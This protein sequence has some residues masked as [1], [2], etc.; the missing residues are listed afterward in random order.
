M[1]L[2]INEN[3]FVKLVRL[4]LK[5]KRKIDQL[6]KQLQDLKRKHSVNQETLVEAKKGKE[7]SVHCFIYTSRLRRIFFMSGEAGFSVMGNQ[8]VFPIPA[9]IYLLKVNN[10]NSRTR[11]EIRSKLTIKT[12][13][14]LVS[15]LLT[16]NIFHTLF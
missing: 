16:L 2:F 13:L 11:C 5:R 14:A 1:K 4:F 15:L 9:G 12:P 8:G 7:N 3:A 10:R 6:T